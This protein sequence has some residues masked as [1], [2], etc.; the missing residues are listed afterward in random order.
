M[1]VSIQKGEQIESYIKRI[2]TELNFYP[3]QNYF[4]QTE[5]VWQVRILAG[6]NTS[7]KV[8]DALIDVLSDFG[9]KTIIGQP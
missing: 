1:S 4:C 7:L 8:M 5:S 9:C 2:F 6:E 3:R